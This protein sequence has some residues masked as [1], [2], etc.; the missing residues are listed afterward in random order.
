ML[1]TDVSIQLSVCA[2]RVLLQ[3]VEAF[4]PART[5]D[6]KE[7][8]RGEDEESCKDTVFA[9]LSLHCAHLHV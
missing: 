8:E 3:Q 6:F 4:C 1:C 7:E 9:Q 5:L 2:G